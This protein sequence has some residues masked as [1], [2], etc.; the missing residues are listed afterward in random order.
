MAN[1]TGNKSVLE[2]PLADLNG[3][4]KQKPERSKE[5]LPEEDIRP[6]EDL[7]RLSEAIKAGNVKITPGWGNRG[8]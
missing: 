6:D 4:G 7:R 5:V 8:R 1:D 3:G 2:A